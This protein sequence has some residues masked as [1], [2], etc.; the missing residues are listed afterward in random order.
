MEFISSQLEAA[1][2]AYARHILR[3][4]AIRKEHTTTLHHYIGNE[5]YRSGRRLLS[6]KFIWPQQL[7]IIVRF[8]ETPEGFQLT[9]EELGWL[10]RLDAAG[11]PSL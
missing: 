5:D 8:I 3:D 11:G 2:V 10:R 4:T 6:H 1:V 7:R 9:T